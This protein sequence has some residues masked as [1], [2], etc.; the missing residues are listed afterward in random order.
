MKKKSTNFIAANY[1]FEFTHFTILPI[2]KLF[3][4]RLIQFRSINQAEPDFA[5]NS[6]TIIS[7]YV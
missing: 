4:T 3:A 6:D 1:I 2:K 7:C 5:Q